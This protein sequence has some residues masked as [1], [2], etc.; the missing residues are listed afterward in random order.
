MLDIELAFG[1]L[2]NQGRTG[3]RDGHVT[4]NGGNDSPCPGKMEKKKKMKKKKLTGTLRE[5]VQ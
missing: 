5:A 2:A 3:A 4:L 1:K